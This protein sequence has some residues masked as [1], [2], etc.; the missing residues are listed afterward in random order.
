M[1]EDAAPSNDDVGGRGIDRAHEAFGASSRRKRRSYEAGHYPK[2]L[3]VIDDTSDCDRAVYY[4]GRRAMRIG[5][6]LVFLRVIEPSYH[7][8]EWLGVADIMQG[9]AQEAAQELLNKYVDRAHGLFGVTPETVIREGDTA[10]EI[11]KL[12]QADDDIA[13]LVL[14][15]GSAK[16][17]PGPLVA[18][19]A[20]TA[21]T[22]PI[23]IIIVPAHLSEEELD[24]LS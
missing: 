19:L 11:L 10:Q 8:V 16:E 3:I 15:A 18:E 17:G 4:A 9:E 5:A 21:G 22:Y 14:A 6:K 2:L 7:Q 13:V 1:T 12:I 23:P 20:R 24:A